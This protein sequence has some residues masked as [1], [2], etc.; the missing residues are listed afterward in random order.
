MQQ[1]RKKHKVKEELSYPKC[2]SS[3]SQAENVL[4]KRRAKTNKQK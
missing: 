3:Q 2:C 4:S 1:K